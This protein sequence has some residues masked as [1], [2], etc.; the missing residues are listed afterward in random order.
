MMQKVVGHAIDLSGTLRRPLVIAFVIGLVVG[1]VVTLRLVD[2]D[3]VDV[4]LGSV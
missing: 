2:V 1:L 3:E 4:D